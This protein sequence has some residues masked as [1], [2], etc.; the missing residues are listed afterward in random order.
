MSRSNDPP[1][2]GLGLRPGAPGFGRRGH[3]TRVTGGRSMTLVDLSTE[4]PVRGP[5]A[6]AL[7]RPDDPAVGAVA[8][9]FGCALWGLEAALVTVEV[10][11]A[12][13]LPHFAIV[14]L[15]DTAVQEARERVRAA[16]RNAG[17][18]FPLRR[19]TVNL[20]PAERRKDGAGFDLPIA[21]AILRATGQLTVDPDGLC[22]GELALDGGLRAVRGAM[23]RVRRALDA[24][25]ARVYVP[26]GN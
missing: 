14:G 10:D 15:P 1:S 26:T 16:I 24:G 7:V 5:I 3:P 2:S 25:I 23:P 11:V 6:C 12:N 4:V 22:L 9:A 19:V 20:A 8:R 13:G 21:L 17:F 18:E